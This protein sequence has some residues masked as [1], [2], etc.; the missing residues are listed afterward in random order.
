MKNT[1]LKNRKRSKG[2]I[3]GNWN[4]RLIYAPLLV[5]VQRIYSKKRN[6][7]QKTFN[8]EDKKIRDEQDKNIRI[9]IANLLDFSDPG[10]AS[11]LQDCGTNIKLGYAHQRIIRNFCNYY[12]ICPTCSR[13]RQSQKRKEIIESVKFI[14]KNNKDR[15]NNTDISFIPIKTIIRQLIAELNDNKRKV[16]KSAIKRQLRQCKDILK[17]IDTCKLKN[18]IRKINSIIVSCHK[19]GC[20][21]KSL[22]L[23]M[24][25]ILKTISDQNSY[26]WKTLTFTKKTDGNFNNDFDVLTASFSKIWNS[27]LSG[28]GVAGFK[29]VELSENGN[30]LH[31][32]LLFYGSDILQKELSIAW[33]SFTGD[34]DIVYIKKI[35]FKDV[36]KKRALKKV[37]NY[38]LKYHGDMDKELLIKWHYATK[39]KH[40]VKS[41]GLFKN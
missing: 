22:I 19:K 37:I 31:I 18:I 28:P 40:L 39:G 32:H 15:K 30:N 38:Q 35:D 34:S 23:H 8:E 13:I 5:D 17:S 29:T 16:K 3:F 36:G 21:R 6:I 1:V 9:D 24:E 41:Y 4:D 27:M 25:E 7:F 14:E 20:N 12:K 11:R 26:T 2:V 33:K 10:A